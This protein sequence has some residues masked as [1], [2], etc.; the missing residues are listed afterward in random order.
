MWPYPS[1]AADGAA[2]HLNAGTFLPDIP[3]ASTF[4]KSISIAKIRGFSVLFMYPWTG[5]AGFSNPKGWDDIPGAHGSTAQAE[6]FRDQ[7][8]EYKKRG[9]GVFGLSTQSTT[10]QLEFAERLGLDFPLL[11]DSNFLFSNALKLPFF[12]IDE[13]TFLKRLTLICIDGKILHTFYPVHPPDRH[14]S[15]LLGSLPTLMKESI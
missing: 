5:R 9:V 13:I 1:P 10:W 2:D 11:S 6:G 7:S 15:D 3:L 14:A 4:G 12:R 8:L